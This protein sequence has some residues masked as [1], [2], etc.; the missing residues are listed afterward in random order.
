VDKKR[1]GGEDTHLPSKWFKS[2]YPYECSTLDKFQLFLFYLSF[3]NHFGTNVEVERIPF[4][5][6]PGLQKIYL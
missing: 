4:Y 5:A 3:E 6:V 1:G 2:F